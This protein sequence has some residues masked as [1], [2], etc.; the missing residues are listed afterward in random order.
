MKRIQL[1]LEKAPT[2]EELEKRVKAGEA[3][4]ASSQAR[5][6]ARRAKRFLERLDEGE[7]LP[8][9]VDY[10]IAIWAFHSDLAMVFLGG[11]VVVDYALRLKR[12]CDESRLWITAYT[13]RVEGYI[14]SKRLLAEGGY[15]TESYP[16]PLAES[17]EDQIV[18]TVRTLLPETFRK[19]R[20]PVSSSSAQYRSK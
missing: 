14:V 7:E 5:R 15:E 8:S 16:T 9:A 1:P 19:P 11:E 20:R 12:E 3:P 6:L 4:K 10:P 18:Q 2:R 17:C 13:N